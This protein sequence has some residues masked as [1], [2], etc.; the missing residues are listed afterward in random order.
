MGVNGRILELSRDAHV[1]FGPP[2]PQ[3]SAQ[4]MVDAKNGADS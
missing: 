1:V 2:L 4:A 3:R